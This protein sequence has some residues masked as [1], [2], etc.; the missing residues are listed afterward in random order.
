MPHLVRH[1][2][3]MRT[4]KSS[5]NKCKMTDFSGSSVLCFLFPLPYSQFTFYLLLFTFY[6]SLFTVPPS[7]SLVTQL[8][9]KIATPIT[10]ARNDGPF[11]F[12]LFPVPRA[13]FSVYLLLFTFYFLLF[14]VPRSLFPLSLVT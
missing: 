10:F 11:H 14:S 8:L 2:I 9:R 3:K 5:R 4:R 1:L 6:C 13:L 12:L 7:L